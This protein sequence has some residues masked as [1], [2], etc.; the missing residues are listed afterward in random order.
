[1]K[2]LVKFFNFDHD[3]ERTSQDI[4]EYAKTNNLTIINIA[5]CHFWGVYVLFEKGGVE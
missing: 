3:C 1:M 2:R 5:P 4:N